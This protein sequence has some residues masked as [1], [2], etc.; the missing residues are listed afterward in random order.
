MT[1]AGAFTSRSIGGRLSLLTA[2]SSS[3]ALSLAG[4][5]LV[6][7][8]RA[9]RLTFQFSSAASATNRRVLRK[10]RSAGV[11]ADPSREPD[12]WDDFPEVE[13]RYARTASGIC[14]YRVSRSGVFTGSCFAAQF[15]IA[16][17]DCSADHETYGGRACN[18]G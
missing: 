7:A 17:N 2:L 1:L 4:F 9:I 10:R 5:A 6:C 16:K 12:P 15:P 11:P 14:W 13:Y 3:L 8:V 18:F